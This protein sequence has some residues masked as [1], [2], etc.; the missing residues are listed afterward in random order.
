M[1]DSARN[2]ARLL[3]S[4]VELKSTM[5]ATSTPSF[6]HFLMRES[7][8]GWGHDAVPLAAELCSMLQVAAA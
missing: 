5:I 1:P 4:R 2:S 6:F 3:S 7:I 8:C